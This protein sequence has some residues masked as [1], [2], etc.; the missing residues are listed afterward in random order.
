MTGTNSNVCSPSVSRLPT[1]NCDG[2][3][4]WPLRRCA[5]TYTGWSVGTL[6]GG[7]TSSM[8]SENVRTRSAQ[9]V[10][11]AAMSGVPKPCCETAASRIS[12]VVSITSV[13]VVT[14]ASLERRDDFRCN[15]N[16]LVDVDD[17][18]SNLRVLDDVDGRALDRV[19]HGD[20]SHVAELQREHGLRQV[21]MI[22]GHIAI[23][24]DAADVED[25]EPE[26][27]EPVDRVRQLEHHG[28]RVECDVG[29]A[30]GPLVARGAG[31]RPAARALSHDDGVHLVSVVGLGVD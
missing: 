5:L 27:A 4:D 3:G 14:S 9:N 13:V 18:A 17:G 29:L 7:V 28:E 19:G 24:D 30:V 22:R 8:S 25:R 15:D 16:R 31:N 11:A 21:A 1:L 20:A 2:D 6:S 12:I 26:R 10:C 23:R